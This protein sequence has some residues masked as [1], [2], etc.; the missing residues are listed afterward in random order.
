LIRALD[1]L[2]LA[3]RGAFHPEP[4]DGVPPLADGTSA[5]TV[6]L[7]GWTGGKQWPA[8]AASA[9]FRDA[10]PH[11]L[12]RWSIRTLI[13]AVGASLLY[14]PPCSP[15]FNPIENAF[16]KLKALRIPGQVGLGFRFDVGR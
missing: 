14:L 11:P 4:L 6:V 16:A 3:F 5:S 1:R 7:L 8:F 15:D 13:E 12:N 2:G 10:L 9:E